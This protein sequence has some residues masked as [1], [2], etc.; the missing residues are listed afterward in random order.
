MTVSPVTLGVSCHLKPPSPPR[1]FCGLSGQSRLLGG[2]CWGQPP[3][4][5]CPLGVL[6]DFSLCVV[7]QQALRVRLGPRTPA[8]V[9]GGPI[10]VLS[11]PSAPRL[12][13]GGAQTALTP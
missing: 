4:P 6:G 10:T 9:A 13:P 2:N 7:T 5:V 12:S 3:T 1:R 11:G 8:I